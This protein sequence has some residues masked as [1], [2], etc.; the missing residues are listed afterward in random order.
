MTDLL[1]PHVPSMDSGVEFRH[2][3]RTLD[4][5]LH[6]PG[7]LD[8]TVVGHRPEWAEFDYEPHTA[9][10]P[11]APKGLRMVWAVLAGLRRAERDGVREVLYLSDDYFLLYPQTAVSNVHAGSLGAKLAGEMKRRP[12]H[13]WTQTLAETW[14]YLRETGADEQRLTCWEMHAPLW[15]EVPSAIEVLSRI[16][17]SGRD[18][19][20]R[21]VYRNVCPP[22]QPAYEAPDGRWDSWRG[23][24][25]VPWAT[26]DEQIWAKR[27][28]EVARRFAEKSRWEK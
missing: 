4:S 13:W 21:T 27:G 2:S 22:R 19:F 24:A 23:V 18:V 5:N 17:D 3:L 14:R 8:L 11:Q 9:P 12:E 16:S 10:D 6:L 26:V 1:I 28:R 7:G 20:W 15:V 25:G